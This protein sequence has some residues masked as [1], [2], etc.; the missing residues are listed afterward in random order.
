MLPVL[1]YETYY[2]NFEPWKSPDTIAVNTD[3]TEEHM[4]S[5]AYL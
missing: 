5:H 3:I 2:I 1:Y 4:K